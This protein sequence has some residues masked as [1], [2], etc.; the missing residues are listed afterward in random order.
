MKSTW[1]RSGRR[2]WMRSERRTERKGFKR[3]TKLKDNQ[4]EGGEQEKGMLKIR[5]THLL[6]KNGAEWGSF[7]QEVL[8]LCSSVASC[9]NIGSRMSGLRGWILQERH[10]H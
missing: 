7:I 1:Q 9:G 3:Q 10:G 6:H 2:V 5:G 8:R 4:D